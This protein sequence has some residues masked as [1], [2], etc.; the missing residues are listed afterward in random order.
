MGEFPPIPNVHF[1]LNT[2]RRFVQSVK[3]NDLHDLQGR[4]I[5]G[6][7]TLDRMFKEFGAPGG[8]C[9]RGL[10]EDWFV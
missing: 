4:A 10:P 8:E 6:L 3:T 5:L 1:L 7:D 2:I 9:P